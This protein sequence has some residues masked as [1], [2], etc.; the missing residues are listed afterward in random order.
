VT[1]R[2]LFDRSAATLVRSWAYL[3]LGSPGAEVVET[4]EAAIAAFV[5]P[6]ERQFLNNAVLA[7]GAVDFGG[8][9]ETIERTYAERRIERFAIWVHETETEVAARL[10]D[11]GY[12]YDSS[13]RTMAMP[14]GELNE[15][16]LAPLELVDRS[17]AEFWRADGL[18]GM[19]PGLPAAGAHFYVSRLDGKDVAMLMALDHAGDCG[20]YMVGTRPAARGR[21]IATALSAHAVAAARER[22]CATGSLQATEMAEGVY[23]SVGFRDLGRFEEYVPGQRG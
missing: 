10:R 22:G 9:L 19:L 4:E 12:R 11:R 16:D 2:E 8:A 13:T 1:D 3:A 17:P 5:A 18:D 15:V 6:P 23:A 14:V 21:G 7:R 20:I